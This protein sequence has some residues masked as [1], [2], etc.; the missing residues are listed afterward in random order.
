[1]RALVLII[2]ASCCL[3]LPTAAMSADVRIYRLDGTLQC[4]ELPA[5]PLDADRAALE[6]L[7]LKVVSQEHRLVPVQVITLCGA[8]A[9]GANTFVVSEDDWKKLQADPA[10]TQGFLEWVFNSDTVSVYQPDGTLQCGWGEEIPL[11]TMAKKLT[12]AGIAIIKKEKSNDGLGH[13]KQCGG[14]TGQINLFEIAVPD[15]PKALKLGFAILV[16]RQ[17]S[18]MTVKSVDGTKALLSPWPFPW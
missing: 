17:P 15:L 14:L 8:P 3:M 4:R 16:Q 12:D 13:T 9:G 10:G 7:G 1:M 6:K 5:R 2:A 18:G 11:D